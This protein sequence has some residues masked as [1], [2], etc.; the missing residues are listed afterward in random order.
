VHAYFS[1][2]ESPYDAYIAFMNVASDLERRVPRRAASRP[3]EA[4][5]RLSP[6]L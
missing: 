4:R 2:Y 6:P 1:P 3:A 5:P